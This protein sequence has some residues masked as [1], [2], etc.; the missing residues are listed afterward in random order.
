MVEVDKY[1]FLANFV[2][3]NVD[4]DVKVPLI[5]GRPFLR[6]SKALIEM[7]ERAKVTYRLTEAM[8]NSLDFDETC[9][10]LDITYKLVDD[11][12]QEPIH[13]NPFEGWP[14]EASFK[15][16]NQEDEEPEGSHLQEF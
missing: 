6:T 1:I 7:D 13:L 15:E 5:L 10:F 16:P 8:G 9:Y 4:E 14:I 12:V 11:Y 3:L 2:V